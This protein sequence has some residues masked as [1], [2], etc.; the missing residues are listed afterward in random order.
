M[1][2]R[3]RYGSEPAGA[4]YSSSSKGTTLD[5]RIK[6]DLVAPGVMI[7]SAQA[8]EA[9]FIDGESCSSSTHAGNEARKLGS[10][11]KYESAERESELYSPTRLMLPQLL[12]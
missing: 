11:T 6:P 7:C 2:I 3:D 1:C 4:V 9:Q 5:G 12:V 10:S 8:E